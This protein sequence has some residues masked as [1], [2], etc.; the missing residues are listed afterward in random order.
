M[1]RYAAT[2]PAAPTYNPPSCHLVPSSRWGW[3]NRVS[4]LQFEGSFDFIQ[5][6]GQVQ[7]MAKRGRGMAACCD[8]V[9]QNACRLKAPSPAPWLLTPLPH[10][11]SPACAAA[12]PWAPGSAPSTWASQRWA[13]CTS[14]ASPSAT[15]PTRTCL[16]TP[17]MVG[18]YAHRRRGMGRPGTIASSGSYLRRPVYKLSSPDPYSSCGT[19]KP[20]PRNHPLTPIPPSPSPAVYIGYTDLPDTGTAPGQYP[21]R[22]GMCLPGLAVGAP[23]SQRPPLPTPAHPCPPALCAVLAPRH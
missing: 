10:V 8:G 15:A 7:A 21:V 9:P 3:T 16:M 2:A 5:G 6:N 11:R 1:L 23:P 4:S 22:W 12:T 17:G 20:G 13:T 18:H 19:H 14:S